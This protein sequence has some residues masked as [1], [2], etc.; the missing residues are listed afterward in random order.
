MH[1]GAGDAISPDRYYVLGIQPDR[2][3]ENIAAF[4]ARL[5]AGEIATLAEQSDVVLIEADQPAHAIGT[6]R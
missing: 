1:L 3:F 6:P 4:S 5:T 2:V